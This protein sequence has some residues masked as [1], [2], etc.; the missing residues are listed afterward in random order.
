MGATAIRRHVPSRSR[1]RRRARSRRRRRV[2][3]VD[4]WP[5]SHLL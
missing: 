2:A 3:S 4:G 5:H 1:V